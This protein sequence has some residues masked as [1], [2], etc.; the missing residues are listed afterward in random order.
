MDVHFYPSANHIGNTVVLQYD[1]R[2][3]G[4]VWVERRRV[5]VG[6]GCPS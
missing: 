4:G 3:V 2:G 6:A 1:V 5:E